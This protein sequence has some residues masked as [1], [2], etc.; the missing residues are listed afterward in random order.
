MLDLRA[1]DVSA[2]LRRPP[3]GGVDGLGAAA[4]EHDLARPGP[5]QRGDLLTRLLDDAARDPSLGVHAARIGAAHESRE[6]G[7][8]DRRTSGRGRRV[9]E[10]V[11]RG[12]TVVTHTSSPWGRDDVVSGVVSP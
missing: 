3:C 12:Q 5:E 7:L 8:H 11:P 1:H 2:S 10:V 9:I 4:R 6:H